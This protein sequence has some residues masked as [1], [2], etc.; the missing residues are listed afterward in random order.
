MAGVHYA[1]IMRT[2]EAG[3]ERGLP[4]FG[5]GLFPTVEDVAK[6]ATLLQDGGQVQGQQLLHPGK[7]AE[8][9]YQTEV[10]GFPSGQMTPDGEV[11]NNLSFWGYPYRGRDGDDFTVPYMM[12]YG[13]SLVALHPSGVTAFRFSDAHNYD[14]G[15]LVWLAD[16]A[17]PSR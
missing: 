10:T 16:G 8:A 2:V 13:G 14:V 12:G 1:P 4:I 7:L 3:G 15:S 6:M 17:G 9:L 5:Y 11:R